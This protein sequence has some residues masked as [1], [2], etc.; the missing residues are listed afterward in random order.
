MDKTT[1]CANTAMPCE[2]TKESHP[3]GWRK[4][5]CSACYSRTLRGIPLEQTRVKEISPESKSAYMLAHN[6]VR[7]LRGRASE[8][9]CVLCGE[10]AEHWAYQHHCA[11]KR[12]ESVNGPYSDNY[13]DYAPMCLPCHRAY[14]HGS[15]E[16]GMCSVPGCNREHSAVGYCDM[17]WKRV[18]R[19][20]APGPPNPHKR[21]ATEEE[22]AEIAR[23]T[24]P[25]QLI[26]ERLGLSMSTVSKYA[27]VG[28]RGDG[29]KR[30]LTDD[31]VR[32]IRDDP[33][34]HS[35]IAPEYGVSRKTICNVKLRRCYRDVV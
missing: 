5:Y 30:K 22:I 18:W 15:P 13:E 27:T 16:D 21:R 24:E 11:T 6:R 26:A 20:G 25:I 1:P 9:E 35:V 3:D 7:R 12:I 10:R 34:P 4:G 29:G 32:S 17:H 23:S 33:R 31:Q 8:H 14:D 2:R 19:H 28:L